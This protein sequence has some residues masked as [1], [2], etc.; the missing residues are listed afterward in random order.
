[1]TSRR[2]ALKRLTQASA[3]GLAASPL[4]RE[5]FAQDAPLAGE[6]ASG[7]A[8]V[9]KRCGVQLYTVRGEMQKSV[10][11]TLARVASIGYKDVE[12]AGYFGRSPRQIAGAL[13]AN[14]LASPS[15][16]IPLA[17]LTAD[18][19][20]ALDI[21]QAIGHK[22]A[23]VPWLDPKERTSID[24][25]KRLADQFNV[26][27]AATR[28]RGIQFAYHNHDFEFERVDGEIPFDVLLARCDPTLVQFEMDLFWTNKAGRDPL[29]YFA[30]HRG[31]FPLVHVKDM[32]RDGTMTEVGA[33]VIPFAKYVAK[34][35]QAGIAHYFVEH[36]NPADPF[37]SI[38]A[39]FKALSA[40]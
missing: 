13:K 35:P 29:D 16:H 4:L 40:L 30:R 24:N 33:G 9:V 15:V 39:S 21:M 2:E 26:A 23:V 36:D 31:R 1:M 12:F 34:A 17:E 20:K 18:T 28:K 25:Y 19:N 5:L 37:A 14:G 8:A 11:A 7:G 32:K 38:T 27:A 3:F 10:E 6:G 22:Y